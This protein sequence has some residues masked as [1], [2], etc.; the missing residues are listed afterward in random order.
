MARWYTCAMSVAQRPRWLICAMPPSPNTSRMSVAPPMRHAFPPNSSGAMPSA[1]AISL[2]RTR[3]WVELHARP[4]GAWKIGSRS[5]PLR[6]ARSRAPLSTQRLL[7]ASYAQ[8]GSPPVNPPCCRL[9]SGVGTA[10]FLAS[11]SL[12]PTTRTIAH[13]CPSLAADGRI[14]STDPHE[15]GCPFH[16]PLLR[17]LPQPLVRQLSH[18][19]RAQAPAE[20]ACPRRGVLLTHAAQR[21]GQRPVGLLGGDVYAR[22]ARPQQLDGRH[23]A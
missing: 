19:V 4:S 14:Q 17:F 12:I 6:P 23:V 1:S 16:A 7:N 15:R 3:D 8:S 18:V 11:P 22:L 10:L 21:H 13:S 9:R 20:P 5:G 2:A